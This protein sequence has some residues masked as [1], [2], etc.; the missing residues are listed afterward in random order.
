MRFQKGVLMHFYC[1][2]KVWT[3]WFSLE[4]IGFILALEYDLILVF[5]LDVKIECKRT[6]QSCQCF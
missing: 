3:T 1:L 4:N 6:D 2:S 5:T